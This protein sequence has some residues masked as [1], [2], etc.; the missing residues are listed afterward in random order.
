MASLNGPGNQEITWKLELGVENPSRISTPGYP[1]IVEQSGHGGATFYE[2]INLINNIEG[3]PTN[4]ATVEEGFWSVIV[5]AA[6]EESVKTGQPVMIDEMLA[7][8]G[9]PL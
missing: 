7:R 2:H 4:T 3:I 5:G 9:I 6:A 1:P 8:D